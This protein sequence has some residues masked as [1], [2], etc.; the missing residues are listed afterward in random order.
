MSTSPLPSTRPAFSATE[1]ELSHKA[2]SRSLVW[3]AAASLATIV[4]FSRISY[5]LLLP[6][7]RADLGGTYSAYGVVTTANLV[8]YLLGTL[9]VPWCLAHFHKPLLLN[10]AALLLM[11]SAMVGSALSLNLVQLSVWRFLV[12]LFSALALVLTLSLTLERVKP[13]GRGRA[14]GIIWMGASLGVCLSGLVA[15]V[16]LKSSSPLAWRWAW[17]AM[18]ASGGVVVIGLHRVLRLHEDRFQLSREAPR[19]MRPTPARQ[20]VGTLLVELLRPRGFLFAT[21]SYIGYGFGYIIYLTFFV[22]LAVQQGLPPVL[23][24]LVWAAMGIAG[25]VSGTMWGWAID[26]WPTGFTLALTLV[27]GALAALSVL[28]HQLVLEAVGAAC[29]GLSVF[30]GPPLILTVLLRRVVSG[31]HYA[32]SY[33]FLNTLF[34]I[35]QVLGPLLGGFLVEQWGL[36]AGTASTS[37]VLFGA[38]FCALAYGV[39]QHR[40]PERGSTGE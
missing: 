33:S 36:V 24:G 34:G 40:L 11:N 15:P 28:T 9:V 29:F 18:G 30:L 35:G 5:G 19:P 4:G 22:S 20:P 21:L 23:V 25:V 39:V 16:L 7:L 27:L 8:G 37:V 12:G 3:W 13:E 14:S 10:S 31:E 2:A 6:S 38:A 1:C 32:S 26:R 17:I